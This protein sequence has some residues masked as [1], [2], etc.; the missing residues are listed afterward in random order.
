MKKSLFLMMALLS[1][2]ALS[3][4]TQPE[5]SDD[6]VA[7]YRMMSGVRKVISI[8]DI[9]GYKTFKC[10]FHTHTVYADAHVSP[11]GRV[12]EDW[13]DGLDVMAMTEH[14]GVHKTGIDMP[15]R[16]VPIVKAKAEGAKFG[17]IVIPGV[18]ITRAKPFGHMNFLFVK[19]ANV[20]S[21]DRYLTDKDGEYL[22]DELGRKINND[23]TLQD[24][25]AAA[26]EQDCFI[27][28]NHPG[29]P[30]R[31]CDMYDIHKDMLAKGQIHAVE[32]CNHQE[33]YP[34][35]LDWFDEY[36]IPMTANTDQ[37]SPIDYN[38]GHVIRPMT[39]VFAKEYTLESIREAM[40]AG[41]MVAFWDQTLAGDATWL[42]QLVHHS[43]QVRVIDA[44]KGR[45]E[46]TNI[47]DI[48][49]ETM[50]G[51]HMNPVILYPRSAI[52]MTVKKGQ[53][54]EFLNCYTGRQHLHTN[55]W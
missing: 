34:K 39:L 19:D 28:W 55:L 20:F 17:M 45:I 30:D 38:Y 33:W 50:Y 22:T 26:L 10:D 2:G 23:E 46:V 14:V 53:K 41:R 42:E 31:K 51:T 27:Q 4:Q 52:I 6:R 11:E 47:S 3:A 25:I 21:E 15:D 9:D 54:I 37:H 16:N 18:E 40:F 1:W 35:V 29:W 49:F 13:Y 7:C 36:H 32:I 48:R 5:N 12:Q 44:A 24:D 43:L 8:P